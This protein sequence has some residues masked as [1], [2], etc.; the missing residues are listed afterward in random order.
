LTTRPILLVIAATLVLAS[1][2]TKK[3]LYKG[4]TAAQ[5]YEQGQK[6]L[7]KEKYADAIKDFEALEA[8]YP[9]GEYSHTTQ[10]GLI[11]AYHEQ[12]ETALAISAADRF[13]R[14]NP[15]HP[16]ADYAYYL[17]GLVAYNQNATFTYK[18]L[19]LDRSAR[20]TTPAQESFDAF[21]DLV[22]RFPNSQYAPDACKRMIYLRNQLANHE[23]QVVEYYM[24]R[25]AYLAAVNRASY[26]I[27][28]FDQTAAIPNALAAMVIAYR[29][30]GMPALSNDA[31]TTLK[32]NFPNY[33]V[34]HSS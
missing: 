17:K 23:L 11:K 3:D 25:G 13:I 1:C 34:P 27:K 24:K 10:L 19:P 22:E 2:S 26:I 29:K 32:A 6:N 31:L 12:G 14:M 16:Q 9:Y 30:L 28:Y 18:H 20:D 4:M 33:P 8:R 5:I 15:R 21:K 7:A